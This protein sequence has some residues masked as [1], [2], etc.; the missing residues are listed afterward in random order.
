MY[1]WEK[2]ITCL[3]GS[4]IEMPEKAEM[5]PASLL[6]DGDRAR[7]LRH[8]AG[9]MTGRQLPD[10]PPSEMR[11]FPLFLDPLEQAE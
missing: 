10:E 6:V 2:S 11:R 8:R 5:E 4:V 3:R 1:G 7:C 9:E